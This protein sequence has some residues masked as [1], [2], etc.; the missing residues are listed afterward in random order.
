MREPF[1]C[2]RHAMLLNVR[3]FAKSKHVAIRQKHW[4]VA[5]TPLTAWRP[6][7]G[8]VHRGVELFHMPI[9]P[10]EAERADELRLTF[11]GS[12]RTALAQ[13]IF[14]R[15][16]GT[17]EVLFGTRPARRVNPG[18]AAERVDGQSGIIRNRR[19][20][21]GPCCSARL[22]ARVLTESGAVL[23][24]LWHPKLARGHSIDSKR[25]QKLAHLLE[26]AGIMRR[27]HKA[28]RDPPV[29]G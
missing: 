6:D 25:H 24:R 3:H 8:S 29:C 22:D 20:A 10:G 18:L 28:T 1:A 21:G 26:F 9:G 16:H 7:E 2:W 12:L 19:Q 13:F 11:L 15:L 14:H 5:E 23:D 27:N 17:S 4:V